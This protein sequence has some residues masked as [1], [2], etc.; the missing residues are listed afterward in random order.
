MLH[1]QETPLGVL[2]VGLAVQGHCAYLGFVVRGGGRGDLLVVL[3]GDSDALEGGF[4]IGDVHGSAE[5]YRSTRG[6]DGTEG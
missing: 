2:T 3:V 5:L 1:L 4:E 6:G